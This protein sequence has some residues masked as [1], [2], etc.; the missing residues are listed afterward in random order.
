MEGIGAALF[1]E[2]G[3]GSGGTIVAR[4]QRLVEILIGKLKGDPSYRLK[5]QYSLRDLAGVL[6]Y[7]GAQVVRGTW[8]RLWMG[9]TRGL[10][11]CGRGVV[12][13]HG[14]HVRVGASVILE[15]GVFLAALSEQGIRLGRN[16]TIGR[17]S[18]LT[19]MGVI[20]ERG[21][22]IE[23]GDCS[24]V[25]AH[26]FLGGQ[27]GITIGRDVIMGPGVRIFSEN[28]RF[29]S[30]E[31]PIR[32]QGEIRR[33]V[34]IEDDCWIGAG[35]TIVDGTTIGRGTVVAAGAVVTRGV[36]AYSVVAGVPAK[37]IKTRPEA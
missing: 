21:V 30:R 26:S 28:H 12:I 7:R 1:G 14:R 22:G 34:R 25:G 6:W 35:V 5:S 4:V 17:G 8:C 20:A 32:L 10:L 19:C 11:F 2:C 36:P 29:D 3:S 27:G 18:V 24:A 31:S 33:G 16:V 15:D 23:I 9:R 13:E 37:I